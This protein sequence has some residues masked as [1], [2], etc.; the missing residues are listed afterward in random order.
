MIHNPDLPLPKDVLPHGDTKRYLDGV[1]EVTA[2]SG[3]GFWTP[4][5]EQY[6][7]HFP[8][9]PVLR[10]VDRVESLAQL[11]AYT[12]MADDEEQ[13]IPTFAGIGETHF[14]GVAVPGDTLYLEITDIQKRG[15]R[16][17]SRGIA[18]VEGLVVCTTTIMGR[19][20]SQRAAGKFLGNTTS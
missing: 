8:N 6:Q 19:L 14:P 7:D 5:S 18:T 12:I 1:Y 4:G 17:Q 9:N 10:A 2:T 20:M 11:G 3:I 15:N 16:F 13:R